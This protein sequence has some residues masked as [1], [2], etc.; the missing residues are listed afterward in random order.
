MF[1]SDAKEKIKQE[2]EKFRTGEKV[3]SGEI[4]ME[5]LDN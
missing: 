2:L 5:D 1:D 3:K 4:K